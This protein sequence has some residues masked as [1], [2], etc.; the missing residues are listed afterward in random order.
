MV[1]SPLSSHSHPGWSISVLTF[2]HLV[3]T[4]IVLSDNYGPVAL[5]AYLGAV[6]PT[7]TSVIFL[8][9][10]AALYRAVLPKIK[11]GVVYSDSFFLWRKWIMDRLFLSPMFRYASERTVS[12]LQAKSVRL[13]SCII[14]AN[15]V[16]FPY[17]LLV[18]V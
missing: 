12:V 18:F 10:V 13:L 14:K 16:Q 8:L 6:F 15:P 1:P 2:H 11:P 9:L 3:V 5:I 17:V 7:M 4:G